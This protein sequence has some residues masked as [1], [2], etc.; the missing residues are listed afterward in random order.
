MENSL[1][2]RK[3]FLPLI[4]SYLRSYTAPRNDENGLK[5]LTEIIQ[6]VNAHRGGKL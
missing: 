3:S 6:Q 1:F 4:V 5:G 2:L